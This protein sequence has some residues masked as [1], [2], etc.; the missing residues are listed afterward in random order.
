MAFNPDG[1]LLAADDENG[2]VY[3]WDIRA[4]RV[5]GDLAIPASAGALSAR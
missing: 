2:S 4:G 3:L 5:A 1:T